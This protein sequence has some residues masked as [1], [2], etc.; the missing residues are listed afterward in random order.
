MDGEAYRD[1]DRVYRNEG[2]RWR[3]AAFM[4]L[5]AGWSTAW[6]LIAWPSWWTLMFA[7][8]AVLGLF[9]FARTLG[10]GVFV[11]SDGMSIRN[12]WSRYQ[13]PWDAVQRIELVEGLHV[14]PLPIVARTTDGTLLPLR[15]MTSRRG[16]AQGFVDS[17]NEELHHARAKQ[18]DS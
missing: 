13:V 8:V 11:N 18:R 3:H 10:E 1:R 5:V 2:R 12:L 17:L 4:L 6:I 14:W 16:R 7:G 15:A 9:A